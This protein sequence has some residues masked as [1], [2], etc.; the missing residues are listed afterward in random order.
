MPPAGTRRCAAC[1]KYR[2]RLP[3]KKWRPHAGLGGGR[4]CKTCANEGRERRSC[5]SC[6]MPEC[7][8]L[9]LG[10]WTCRGC[11]AAAVLLNNELPP[12]RGVA[13][14]NAEKA[15]RLERH[16]AHWAQ[17]DLWLLP[18]KPWCPLEAARLYL[19]R[20]YGL[21]AGV[22]LGPAHGVHSWTNGW[23]VVDR[24]ALAEHCGELI[25]E[26][27]WPK[28]NAPIVVTGTRE[29]DLADSRVAVG[30]AS[31]ALGLPGGSAAQDPRLRPFP[32]SLSEW[33][34]TSAGWRDAVAQNATTAPHCLLASRV[35]DA[36]GAAGITVAGRPTARLDQPGPR[37][38]AFRALFAS[39]L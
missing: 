25:V 3:L 1:H 21:V 2:D 33:R 9:C 38:N 34:A 22:L 15:A 11:R 26:A 36:L 12:R 18:R 7:C 10:Q 32:K 5:H 6:G 14:T 29:D 37:G 20:R 35:R 17:V 16:L 39:T 27:G 13:L 24:A 4:R 28:G 31:E 19:W 8:E 30:M 23:P